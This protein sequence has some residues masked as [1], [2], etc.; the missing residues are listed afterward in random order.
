MCLNIC[1]M[2]QVPWTNLG[3]SAV[4]VYI[5]RLYILAGPKTDPTEDKDGQYEVGRA[6]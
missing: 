1:C 4:L 3:R 6:T 2:L 5:D